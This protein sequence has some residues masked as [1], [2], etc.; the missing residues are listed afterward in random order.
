MDSIDIA[1]LDAVQ[2]DGRISVADLADE[3]GLSSA[4][5]YRRLTRLEKDGAI[6]GYHADLDPAAFG[7]STCAMVGVRCLTHEEHAADALEAFVLASSD[8]VRC[9]NVTGEFDYLLVVMVRSLADYERFTREIR[10]V[11][12]IAQI[13]SYISLR[14][15]KERQ[16]LDLKRMA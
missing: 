13:H 6:R 14:T 12:G 1:I 8:I 3:V 15:V 16:L 5:V 10:A 2:R 7:L 4:P 9:D 11:P